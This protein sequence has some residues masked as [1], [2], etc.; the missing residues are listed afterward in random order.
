M[1]KELDDVSDEFTEENSMH[2][3][4]QVMAFSKV[5]GQALCFNSRSKVVHA[6]GQEKSCCK[7]FVNEVIR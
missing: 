6:C 2:E 7:K 5:T 4:I 3:G 1:F